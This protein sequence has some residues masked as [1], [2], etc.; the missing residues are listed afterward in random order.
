MEKE[1]L[2]EIK[3]VQIG[4]RDENQRSS[5]IEDIVKVAQLMPYW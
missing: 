3:R 1:I 4:S 2:I 5:D